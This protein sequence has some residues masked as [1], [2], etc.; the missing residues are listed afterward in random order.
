MF[1]K[2]KIPLVFAVLC[3]VFLAQSVEAQDAL[4]LTKRKNKRLE[5]VF[6]IGDKI[7]FRLRNSPSFETGI[8]A[9]IDKDGFFTNGHPV[10]MDSLAVVSENGRGLKFGLG[11]LSAAVGG[12]IL[13]GGI[14]QG[15]WVYPLGAAFFGTGLIQA[16]LYGTRL[17]LHNR[18]N[19]QEK[20]RFDVRELEK[21]PD[22]N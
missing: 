3:L 18:Y 15:I 7:T 13:F 10:R 16:G 11:V 12:V 4:V 2:L 6:F 21:E 5:K 22:N 9:A 14:F 19:V 20:W 17:L 1:S 8:I